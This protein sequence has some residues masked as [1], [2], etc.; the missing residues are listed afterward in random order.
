MVHRLRRRSSLSA[1]GGG[2]V[3][4]RDRLGRR[5]LRTTCQPTS[6]RHHRCFSLK[7]RASPPPAAPHLH[8]AEP[9]KFICSLK[10]SL[11][12]CMTDSETNPASL[13]CLFILRLYISFR[14]L[15]LAENAAAITG[16][17][18]LSNISSVVP[19]LI[20]YLILSLYFQRIKN[21][22][23]SYSMFATLSG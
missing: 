6:A 17:S 16:G 21:W 20:C 13:Q 2:R 1:A 3:E 11:A 18:R 10:V 22:K 12:C 5:G 9:Q 8:E 4:R 15:L 23:Y 19:S 14:K 7:G